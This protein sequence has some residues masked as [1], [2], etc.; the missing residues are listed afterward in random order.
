MVEPDESL[1][2]YPIINVKTFM[3]RRNLSDGEL[4][5]GFPRDRRGYSS[6]YY[7][8]YDEAKIILSQLIVELY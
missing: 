5:P 1:Q 8:G 3:G 6:L 7:R 2:F 4:N